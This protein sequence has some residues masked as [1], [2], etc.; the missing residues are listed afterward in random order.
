LPLDIRRRIDRD[1]APAGAGE[2]LRELH[3]LHRADPKIFSARIVRCVVQAA[4]GDLAAARRAIALAQTDWRD[5]VV[6]AEYDNQ[7]GERLR[8]LSVPFE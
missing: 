7:F 4:A 8:D 1:F 5:L 6:W 3:T 2:L